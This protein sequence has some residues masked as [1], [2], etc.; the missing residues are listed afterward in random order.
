MIS[1]IYL[2]MALTWLGLA[3]YHLYTGSGRPDLE[4]VISLL[5]FIAYECR[6]IQMSIKKQR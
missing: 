5:L 6:E 4:T 2:W 3:L 1:F